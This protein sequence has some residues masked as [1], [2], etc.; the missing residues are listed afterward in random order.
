MGTKDPREGLGLYKITNLPC[1]SSRVSM[2]FKLEPKQ[3]QALA[4]LNH[5]LAED[6]NRTTSEQEKDAKDALGTEPSHWRLLC[7]VR[8]WARALGGIWRS[9]SAKCAEIHMTCG[10]T[11]PAI[12]AMNTLTNALCAHLSVPSGSL[13][14]V[15]NWPES[16]GVRAFALL[17]ADSPVEIIEGELITKAIL[18][19]WEPT[20]RFARLMAGLD[21]E[22]PQDQETALLS[23]EE[24]Q[25]ILIATEESFRNA[26]FEEATAPYCEAVLAVFKV[27]QMDVPVLTQPKNFQ[28]TSEAEKRKS[29]R[30]R[31]QSV[32]VADRREVLRRIAS[33]GVKGIRYCEKVTN[34]GLSTPRDWQKRD[35][36]P[37]SYRDA[38]NHPNPQQR[39]KFRQRI[40]DEKYKAS[41]G[42]S[43]KVT[44]LAKS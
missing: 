18:P 4:A 44:S 26:L 20:S 21:P 43:P 41:K 2:V 5:L 8:R 7:A 6:F 40:S 37:T 16:N 13:F 19:R 22:P 14:G 25:K 36:C 24:T 38:W 34:A 39:E 12:E 17:V 28:S 10:A 27:G 29:A 31:P 42:H 30:G 32:T 1:F 33:T 3:T 15:P 23:A 11:D 35:A 9:H